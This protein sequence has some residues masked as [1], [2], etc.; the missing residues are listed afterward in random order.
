MQNSFVWRD[1]EAWTKVVWSP[2]LAESVWIRAETATHGLREGQAGHTGPEKTSSCF[3]QWEWNHSKSW[4]KLSETACAV[5]RWVALTGNTNPWWHSGKCGKG[6]SDITSRV[7]SCAQPPTGLCLQN[8][9]CVL[10]PNFWSYSK[11]EE[12]LD[13]FRQLTEF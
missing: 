11:L 3:P 9:P 6:D 8:S 4:T 12:F 2:D 1:F 5:R 10:H 13:Q 7:K